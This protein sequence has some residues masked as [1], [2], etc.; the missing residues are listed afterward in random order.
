MQYPIQPYTHRCSWI[1][2]LNSPYSHRCFWTE[3]K[4]GRMVPLL[5]W[6]NTRICDFLKR[7]T[8]VD[9]Q[10][11]Y[12]IVFNIYLKWAWAQI[13]LWGTSGSCLNMISSLHGGVF[14]SICSWSTKARLMNSS[15]Y[16]LLSDSN[17]QQRS[18]K[19]DKILMIN[20]IIFKMSLLMLTFTA[21]VQICWQ[22]RI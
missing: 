8:H 13:R 11:Q 2:H 9:V 20:L 19:D 7:I 10:L 12:R 6:A 21:P 16:L 1:E 22:L 5:Y 17:S 4:P 14:T 15:S 18:F 3:H